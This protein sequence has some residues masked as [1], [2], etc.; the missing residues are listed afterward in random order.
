MQLALATRIRGDEPPEAHT[1]WKRRWLEAV[2]TDGLD[3]LDR[4]RLYVIF[5]ALFSIHVENGHPPGDKMYKILRS[6][7]AIYGFDVVRHDPFSE[8]SCRL[9]C[10]LCPRCHADAAKVPFEQLTDELVVR[11]G[12]FLDVTTLGRFSRVSTQC[13]GCSLSS[14]KVTLQ[15]RG[16]AVSADSSPLWQLFV[17][18]WTARVNAYP[19]AV[20]A[21]AVSYAQAAGW[22]ARL[23][24]RRV[25]PA[26]LC[27]VE[28]HLDYSQCTNDRQRTV[29][30]AYQQ[31]IAERRRLENPS[32]N[33]DDDDD[34]E[35]LYL[36]FEQ[37][38]AVSVAAD[39]S[40]LAAFELQPDAIMLCSHQEYCSGS[41]GWHGARFWDHTWIPNR[42]HVIHSK[43]E[44]VGFVYAN[45]DV[46]EKYWTRRCYGQAVSLDP[47]RCRQFD[48]SNASC[49]YFQVRSVIVLTPAVG[50]VPKHEA[51]ATPSRARGGDGRAQVDTAA[52]TPSEADTLDYTG[53]FIVQVGSFSWW[54]VPRFPGDVPSGYRQ[55]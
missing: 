55:W 30:S 2:E 22:T 36:P 29:H 54:D 24:M 13:R 20:R 32:Q 48:D 15:R 12:S 8:E 44:R 4:A 37:Q 45:E 28:L 7:A 27:S 25:A 16:E 51:L 9:F 50:R 1:V 21:R 11:V 34:P 33:S 53:E 42:A 49:Y 31:A 46:Q 3:D 23:E 17:S 52:S 19:L 18:D 35:V 10:G 5:D 43:A 26:A 40:A 39:D 47:S 38:L 6:V 14:A 41:T